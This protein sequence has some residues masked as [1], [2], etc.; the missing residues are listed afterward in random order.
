MSFDDIVA[1]HCDVE[2]DVDRRLCAAWAGYLR[3]R[4]RVEWTHVDE[5]DGL[6]TGIIRDIAVTAP[7]TIWLPRNLG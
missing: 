6:A 7:L 1:L 5:N 3:R 2:A 4:R